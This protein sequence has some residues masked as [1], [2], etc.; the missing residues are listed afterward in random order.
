MSS[1]PQPLP[2]ADV[3]ARIAHIADV[4][5]QDRRRAEYATV[6]SALYT[7]LRRDAPTLIVVAGDVFDSKTTASALNF[8]DVA[9]FLEQLTLI[10]PVVLISGNHDTNVLT[11]G[12]LDLLTPLLTTHARLQAPSLT[13]WRSSGTYAAHGAL[14][15]VVAPDG[16]L[17]SV[18]D[19]PADGVLRVCLFHEDV[20]GARYPNGLEAF[21]PR[22]SPAYLNQYDLALGGHI[23]R[24][25]RVAR[26][27]W[28]CGST[29]QQNIGEDHYGHGYLLWERTSGSTLPHVVRGVD[30]Y[31]ERGFVRVRIVDGADVTV[32]PVPTKPHYWEVCGGAT[33]DAIAQQYAALFGRPPRAVQDEADHVVSAAGAPSVGALQR[34]FRDAASHGAVITTILGADHACLAAVLAEHG[35]RLT[36]ASSS[37]ARV[38]LCRLVFSNMFCYGPANEVDFTQLEHCVSGV[39]AANYAGKSALIDVILIALYGRSPRCPVV[40]GIMRS[41]AARWSCTLDF[42]VDARRGT[43]TRGV[44]R[45]RSKTMVLRATF[46]GESLTGGTAAETADALRRVVGT[47]DSALATTVMMQRCALFVNMTAGDRKRLLADVLE[48]GAFA[49]LE[50]ETQKELLA[51]NGELRGLGAT[52]ATS[53]RAALE[54]QRGALAAAAAAT[55]AQLVQA[56]LDA[57]AAQAALDAGRA[58][59]H[60]REL[61]RAQQ[62][63]VRQQLGAIA[64]QYALVRGDGGAPCVG[65]PVAGVGALA[66]ALAARAALVP[67]QIRHAFALEQ[68]QLCD[69]ALAAALARATQLSGAPCTVATAAPISIAAAGAHCVELEQQQRALQDALAVVGSKQPRVG[70]PSG[71]CAGEPVGAI[72]AR[73][74]IAEQADASGTAADAAARRFGDLRRQLVLGGCAHCRALTIAMQQTCECADCAC[75]VLH[76]LAAAPPRGPR[77]TLADVAGSAQA[78]LAAQL[79]AS[80][81]ALRDAAAICELAQLLQTTVPALAAACAAQRAQADAAAGVAAA[82]ADCDRTVGVQRA[83]LAAAV[84]GALDALVE[85]PAAEVVDAAP[86]VAARAR[87]AALHQQRVDATLQVARCD[88]AI[89]AAARNAL[90]AERIATVT[91][92]R[93]IVDAYRQVLRPRGGIADVLLQKARASL[94]THINA[95][96]QDVGA[97]FVLTIDDEYELFHADALPISQASGYQKYALELALRTSLWRLAPIVLPACLIIDEGFTECD[98]DH[99][100]A[101]TDFVEAYAASATAPPLVFVVSH[102]A[103]LKVRIARP[104]YIVQ[105]ASP[106]YSAIGAGPAAEPADGG[107]VPTVESAAG[108]SEPTA[109]VPVGAEPA[110]GTMRAIGGG[111]FTCSVCG[112]TVV[113]RNIARHLASARHAAAARQFA[114]Q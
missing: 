99:L 113:A 72:L 111:R 109:A 16:V 51:L 93:D 94:E 48:L 61:A 96:L 102:L 42:E 47:L 74:A 92:R 43:I 63:S 52:T 110:H 39:I 37:H 65:D 114:A 38:R 34:S 8:A 1:F 17:P 82:V 2:T 22:L 81:A 10:A 87:M 112:V 25:Q 79:A 32:Q 60:A 23:H 103:R 66:A 33:T 107:S 83:L 6:F 108:G 11:P 104:L 26:A 77:A 29:V 21:A 28:Y 40:G 41:G 54:R 7:S 45:A 24:R 76:D 58:R 100:D 101:M 20:A 18:P 91:Q 75:V 35:A 30:V 69:R 62:Q 97:G 31:N 59:L 46:D 86:L 13:Y 88:V 36:A 95:A 80:Q 89:E 68:Q 44:D 73:L 70:R 27:A 71:E 56:A 15:T 57:D 105:H 3:L 14:W 49:R 67:Q 5:I 106:A 78:A 85:L 4:H 84:Y 12:A 53:D 19:P 98:D 55:A 64:A 9:A 90:Q 50:A